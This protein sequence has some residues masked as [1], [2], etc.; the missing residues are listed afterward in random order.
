MGRT[1]RGT[2]MNHTFQTL[3]FDKIR[4]LLIENAHTDQ[5]R[6][7][8]GRLEPYLSEDELRHS[9]K[10][11]TEARRI[12]DHMGTPPLSGMEDMDKILITA[13]QGGCLTPEQLEYTGI[14]LTAVRRLKD[15]LCRCKSLETGLAFYE[16]DVDGLEDLQEEIRTKIRGGRV[17]DYASKLLKDLRQEIE[18]TEA[19][20]KARAESMLKN[21]KE[22][23]SDSFVTMRSGHVCLPVKKDYKFRISGSVIDKSSTGQ[24]LFIEPT[25]VGQM[26]A[27]LTNL[28]LDEENE[29]RRIL[30]TLSD[31]VSEQEEIFRRNIRVMEKLD[32]M[33]A[34]GKLSYDMKAVEPEIN[35]GR[36]IR[37]VNGR[38]PFLN[39]ETCVPLNFTIGGEI[40]G[41][42]ITG[43]N[44]GGKTVSI[45]TVGLLSLMA[46]S[47]LH[48]PCESGSFAMNNQ[49]LCDIG[50]GQNITENLSTFSAHITN[51]LSILK[52]ASRDSLVI[53]DELGSGTDP[54][55][56][57]GIA[58]AIL[59]ELR[60][61]ECLFL[62]TTHYPEVKTYAEKTEGIINARMAFDRES[63][64]P[65]Y[66]LE[67]GEGGESCALYIAKRL[68]MPKDMLLTAGKA[69]Y[70]TEAIDLPWGDCE[71]TIRR[72][73]S[74]KVTKHKEIRTNT[75]I[76]ER[77]QIGDCVMVYPEQKLGIV[78][79]KVNEQGKLQVQMKTQKVWLSHK[80]VKLHVKAKELY[81]ED[82]DFSI[83]FDSVETRKARH[84]MGR[85]YRPDLEI[86]VEEDRD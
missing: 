57:M 38:H 61:R 85:K 51:V 79:R 26:S 43:P 32:Y 54:A 28:K 49:V 59:E 13:G 71:E 58:V 62:A 3:E 2:D 72:E 44:T 33:F 39:P 21:Q 12:L 81:P 65:L 18:Q 50:D 69:A 15:F 30:Y 40:R 80:R 1:D 84:Q 78:C 20:I 82:Y 76:L 67:V 83:V 64:S 63:L 5:A 52:K 4:E 10:E 75:E 19:K 47:G 25:A 74:P 17:D 56:G 34:K 41:V 6:I 77:Y 60:K 31:M 9:M 53:L 86:A 42:I 36:W 35:T 48:V 24:T 45:K 27:E 29:E 68:G 66:H 7:K 73:S 11:T 8:L 70:G 37:I 46:Q 16:A 22:C 55:E 14:S 23:F